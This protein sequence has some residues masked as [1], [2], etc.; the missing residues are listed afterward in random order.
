[1]NLRS[2]RLDVGR[3]VAA[4]CDV[5]DLALFPT[6]FAGVMTVTFGA[7][8]EFR[9][10]HV[11]LWCLGAVRR[12]GL[13]LRVERWAVALNDMAGWFDSAAGDKGGMRVEVVGERGPGDRVR[14]TWQLTAPAADGPE[15][16]CM[17]AILLARKIAHGETPAR[18][19]FECMGFL[20]LSDFAPEFSRW[21]ITT[22]TEEHTL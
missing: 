17:P 13:R 10:Q 4:A 12:S 18:G 7:A 22:R 11:A 3:R 2:V 8:L 15:I 9:S 1:M 21:K 5:P 20:G 14:R 16:P 19:A 6:R